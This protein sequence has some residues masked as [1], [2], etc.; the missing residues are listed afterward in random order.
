MLLCIAYCDELRIIK[1]QETVLLRLTVGK[2]KKL[3]IKL[4][5]AQSYIYFLYELSQYLGQQS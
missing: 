4:C 3:E 5:P 1:F 2:E